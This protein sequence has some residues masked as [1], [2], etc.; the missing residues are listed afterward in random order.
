MSFTFIR[1]KKACDA[2][3]FDRNTLPHKSLFQPFSAYYA[4]TGT[5]IMTFVGGY[6]VFLKGYVYDI[7]LYL[8]LYRATSL[9]DLRV[10][11]RF[12]ESATD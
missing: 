7:S 2:Q 5:M 11:S 9:R 10:P 4:L 8:V 6:P 1:W 3:G 12:Q